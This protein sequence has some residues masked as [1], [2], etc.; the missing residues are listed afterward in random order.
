MRTSHE[1]LEAFARETIA[2][3]S[4]SFAL[5]SQLFEP[6]MRLH[7]QL[8]YAWCRHCDDVIDGQDLGGDAPDAALSAAERRGR[9]DAL[10][11][12]TK[13]ALAG[14]TVDEPAFDGLGVVARVSRL[15]QAYP[16]AH[17]DGFAHDVDGTAPRTMDDLLEYSYGVAGVVGVMMAI[18][19]GVDPGDDETLDRACDLGLAF[20]LTNICRDVRDD[21]EG[22]RVYLPTDDLA[23]RGVEPTP[24]GLL[25]ARPEAVFAVVERVLDEA[26]RYY[27]SATQGIRRLPP[28]AGAAIAAAR[29]VYRDIG[30]T[31]RQFGPEGLARRTVVGASRKAALAGAGAATG[32]AAALF[33]N[34]QR[35]APRTGLWPRPAARATA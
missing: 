24:E 21:A 19:M 1:T 29:N 16:M 4:K 8:L 10:R 27:A 22:G 12:K 28:R 15:P 30:L 33:L 7:A 5:A 2:K 31:L 35:P 14:R 34:G 11:V 25:R 6:H 32:A 17:L 26:D 23:G 3:G 9:L 18:V 20:Q 13:E